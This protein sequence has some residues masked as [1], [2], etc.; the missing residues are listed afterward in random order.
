MITAFNIEDITLANI[1]KYSTIT[2]YDY[3]DT[4]PILFLFNKA[5]LGFLYYQFILSVRKNTR[6]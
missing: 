2:K 3:A 6:K 4:H 5:S 1:I